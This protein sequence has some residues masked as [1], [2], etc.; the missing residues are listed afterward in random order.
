[1]HC[2]GDAYEGDGDH[3]IC[4]KSYDKP[5]NIEHFI[6]EYSHVHV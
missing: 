1:M 4:E 6:Q 5:S 3:F 2:I